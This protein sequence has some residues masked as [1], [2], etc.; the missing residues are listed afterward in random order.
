M[1]KL[2][3]VAKTRPGPDCGSDHELLIA[4]FRLNLKKV[5]KTTDHSCGLEL[6]KL[7]KIVDFYFASNF[8]I[9]LRKFSVLPLRT[10]NP[11]IYQGI[12]ISYP[13]PHQSS[14][15]TLSSSAEL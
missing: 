3:S 10:A 1:E 15:E 4:K 6:I 14:R 11:K 8:E 2:Y 13:S 7:L 5:G 12:G 9:L